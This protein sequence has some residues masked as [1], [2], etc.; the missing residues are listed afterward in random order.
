M[1]AWI[2]SPINPDELENTLVDVLGQMEPP[3]LV[4][5]EAIS[6][7][8][9]PYSSSNLT[10]LLAEDN[11][12]NQQVARL[13]L[14]KLGYPVD[15]VN[16]GQEALLALARTDYDVVLMDVEMPEMDGLTATEHIRRSHARSERRWIIAVTAYSMEGD[17]ERCLASGM[18][19]YVSKP[20]RLE[21]LQQALQVAATALQSTSQRIT[22]VPCVSA[23]EAKP[24]P[25]SPCPE[26]PAG[27]TLPP[28]TKT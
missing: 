7:P 16:N 13:L 18:N 17:R 4:S 10:I 22:T 21:A 12:I 8:L 25:S 11:L 20:I 9:F 3:T 14:K 6:G 1:Q 28:L 23:F 27:T 5:T 15:V 26:D 2:K 24:S 19:D